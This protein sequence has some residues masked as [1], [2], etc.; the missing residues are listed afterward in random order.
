MGYL[1]WYSWT[2]KEAFDEWHSEAKALLNMPLTG[3]NAET[4]E[5]VNQGMTTEYTEGIVVSETDVRAWVEHPFAPGKLG[6]PS[7]APTFSKP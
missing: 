6:V 5:Q 7:E 4:G 2:S 3:Y 1:M